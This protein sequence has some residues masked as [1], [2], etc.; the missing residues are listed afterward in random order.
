M[1]LD[2]KDLDHKYLPMVRPN[3]PP[4]RR[5]IYKRLLHARNLIAIDPNLFVKQGE[6]VLYAHLVSTDLIQYIEGLVQNV[7]NVLKK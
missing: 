2:R 6:T 1:A 5:K 4:I 7:G 3:H